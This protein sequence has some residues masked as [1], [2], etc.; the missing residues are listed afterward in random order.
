MFCL[1]ATSSPPDPSSPPSSPSSDFACSPFVWPFFCCRQWRKRNWM[2][3]N[4]WP[5]RGLLPVV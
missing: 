3:R 2:R 4:W 5:V 1:L